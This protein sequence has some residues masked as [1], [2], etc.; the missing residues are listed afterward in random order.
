MKTIYKIFL[1]II[2]G[3]LVFVSCNEE[4]IKREA[5]PDVVQGCQGVYFPATNTSAFELEPTD[6]TEI[7]LQISRTATDAATIPLIAE[8]NEQGVFDVP[9]SVSFASGGMSKDIKVTFPRAK[10]GISYILKLKVEGDAYVNAYAITVPYVQT[11]VTRIKW[12]NIAEPGIMVE[13][14][15]GTFFTVSDY[16]FYVQIQKA[17]LGNSTL[18]RLVHSYRLP[19]KFDGNG[20]P[21]PDQDGIFDGYPYNEPENMVDGEYLMALTVNE[22]G[23]V[24]MAPCELG[25]DYGYGMFSAGSFDNLPGTINGDVISFPANSLYCSMANFDNG[26]KYPAK[27]TIIYLTKQSYLDANSNITDYNDVEYEKETGAINAFASSAFSEEW[28]QELWK[29]I[30]RKPDDENSPYKD[31][32]YLPNLYSES[33]GLAFYFDGSKITIPNNQPTGI[34]FLENDIFVSPSEKLSS[35]AET[36]SI[37]SLTTYSFGLNFHL[38]DGTSLGDFTESFYYGKNDIERTVDDFCG[39][40]ILQ[41]TSRYNQASL[42]YPVRITKDKDNKTLK[43]KGLLDPETAKYY[44]YS[45]D[46]VSAVYDAF[47]KCLLLDPQSLA[48]SFVYQGEEFPI[49]FVTYSSATNDIYDD[50]PIRIICRYNDVLQFTNYKENSVPIDGYCYYVVRLGVLDYIPYSITLSPV[51]EASSTSSILKGAPSIRNVPLNKG[52]DKLPVMTPKLKKKDLSV[53]NFSPQ[54][55]SDSKKRAIKSGLMPVF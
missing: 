55:K 20:N 6:P 36:S 35:N 14:L 19:S 5:S 22:A 3:I 16:P 50:Q 23:S 53:D 12:D 10:E 28:D 26:Y 15:I 30:D 8:I 54:Q 25:M 7:I 17:S 29:A 37:T 4:D 31:L 39:L 52:A 11:T 32:Y 33:L 13:G 46:E 49:L 21:I 38:K 42:E 24:S 40:F 2:A 9:E 44:K 47:E 18:Y 41:A 43:I 1:I 34:K 51:T 48:E 45:N 27:A